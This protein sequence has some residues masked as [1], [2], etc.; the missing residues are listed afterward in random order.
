MAGDHK[1]WERLTLEIGQLV[2]DFEFPSKGDGKPQGSFKP[3]MTLPV[4][5]T[6]GGEVAVVCVTERSDLFSLVTHQRSR[7][8]VA[9][10]ES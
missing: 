10:L 3:G 5:P 4:G 6:W 7:F 8:T 2:Q 9:A 1:A